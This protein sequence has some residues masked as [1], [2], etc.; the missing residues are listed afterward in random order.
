MLKGPP[1]RP[2]ERGSRKSPSSEEEHGETAKRRIVSS[3]KR[4]ERHVGAADDGGLEHDG[5]AVMVRYLD[6]CAIGRRYLDVQDVCDGVLLVILVV[7]LTMLC[8]YVTRKEREI[9]WSPNNEMR[10][11]AR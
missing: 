5:L 7:S 2:E 11:E 10:Y 4:C 6:V 1:R 9:H 3:K 8:V